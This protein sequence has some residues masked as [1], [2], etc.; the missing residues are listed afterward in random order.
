MRSCSGVAD[1]VYGIQNRIQGGVVTDCGI[2]SVQVV[3]D[4]SRQ[5]DTGHI[6][7][8]AKMR[9]PDREPPPITTRASIPFS[10]CYRIYLPSFGRGK[11]FT[12]RCFQDST[13]Q[14]DDVTYILALEFLISPVTKPL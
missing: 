10:S 11:L 6:K 8:C 13:A 12:A 7:F 9:A 4:G 2:R 14:L 3:V 5:T 1:F